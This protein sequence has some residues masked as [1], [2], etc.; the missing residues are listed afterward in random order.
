ME[1]KLHEELERWEKGLPQY[2]VYEPKGFRDVMWCPYLNEPAIIEYR[3]KD[4]KKEPYCP[5]C[6]GNFEPESH[7]FICH[8]LKPYGKENGSKS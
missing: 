1:I 5:N 2:V 3:D 6:N 4:G 7:P 8:I